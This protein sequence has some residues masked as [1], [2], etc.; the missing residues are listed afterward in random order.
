MHLPMVDILLALPAYVLVLSRI[1]G[2]MLMAPIYGSNVIPKRIRGGLAVMVAALVFPFVREQAPSEITLSMAIVGGAGE[3]MIGAIIGLSLSIL[4]MAAE[5]A[6]MIVGRQA[7]LALANV[8]DPTQNQRVSIMGQVYSISLTTVF[9]LAGGH[10][11]TMAALLDTFDVIPLLSFRLD[12]TF[13]L[14]LVEAL[15]A[16]FILG[17]RLAGPVLIALFML[18]TALAFLSRTMPQLNI[19][20]VGF[21]LR[22]LAALAVAALALSACQDLMLDAV[23][24]SVD[25]ARAAFGLSPDAANLVN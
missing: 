8:F 10:R 19:M 12:E 11:A 7:G 13:V 3:M 4:I 20:T 22:L 18:G 17:I 21:T 24:D 2:L 15:A 14:L 16:T 9:L 25:L 1:T 6:G 5:V 23:W